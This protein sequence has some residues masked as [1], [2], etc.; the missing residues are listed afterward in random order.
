MIWPYRY[1]V[2]NLGADADIPI[3]LL[4]LSRLNGGAR[5]TN[6]ETCKLSPLLS[7]WT[8]QWVCFRVAITK[9]IASVQNQ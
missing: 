6:Q 2:E 3:L 1:L 7:G 5:Q 8:L 4:S 9:K